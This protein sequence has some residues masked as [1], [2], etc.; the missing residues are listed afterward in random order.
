MAHFSVVTASEFI[1]QVLFTSL[2]T[3]CSILSETGHFP[4]EIDALNMN[5]YLTEA[6]SGITIRSRSDNFLFCGEPT[7]GCLSWGLSLLLDEGDVDSRGKL[8]H[9]TSN[10]AVCVKALRT[11]S[12]TYQLYRRAGPAAYLVLWYKCRKVFCW[13]WWKWK[14]NIG[15][16]PSNEIRSSKTTNLQGPSSLL[17]AQRLTMRQLRLPPSKRLS[18]RV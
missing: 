6:A 5:T 10:G 4:C 16:K 7:I 18:N 15:L 9:V 13:L 11:L 14:F 17:T 12:P 8:S 1:P 2:S 3:C